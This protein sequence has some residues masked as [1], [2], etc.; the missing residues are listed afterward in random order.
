[1]N[2]Y[3]HDWHRL[4]HQ[5]LCA[6]AKAGRRRHRRGLVL[7]GLAFLVYLGALCVCGGGW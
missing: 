4:H 1:M 2:T 3:P 7:A 5:G 6:H